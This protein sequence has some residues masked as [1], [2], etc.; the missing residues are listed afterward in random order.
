MEL[1]PY[2]NMPQMLQFHEGMGDIP[3]GFRRQ[4]HISDRI[5]HSSRSLQLPARSPLPPDLVGVVLNLVPLW[6]H[7]AGEGESYSCWPIQCSFVRKAVGCSGF[8][9]LI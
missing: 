2:L 8:D 5:P 3:G 7:L 4:T 6:A 9:L 1:T